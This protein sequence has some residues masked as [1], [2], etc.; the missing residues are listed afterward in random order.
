VHGTGNGYVLMITEL[1]TVSPRWPDIL[2]DILPVIAPGCHSDG[3]GVTDRAN[4]HNPAP[5]LPRTDRPDLHAVRDIRSD[6]GPRVSRRVRVHH[7]VG[8]SHVM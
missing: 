5:S 8:S 1:G 6:T 3:D 7:A 2:P 4:S